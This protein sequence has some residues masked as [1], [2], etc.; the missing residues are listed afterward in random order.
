MTRLASKRLNSNFFSKILIKEPPRQQYNEAAR[1][2]RFL[3]SMKSHLSQGRTSTCHAI[4]LLRLSRHVK[5]CAAK[6]GVKSILNPFSERRA[7]VCKQIRLGGRETKNEI[8]L[9]I[10]SGLPLALSLEISRS[11]STTFYDSIPLRFLI[12]AL[13]W[14]PLV[15][16]ISKHTFSNFPVLIKFW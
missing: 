5:K 12:E 6:Q 3:F 7:K 1:I 4:L 8:R 11:Q 2:R 16:R 15:Y 13:N 9:I 14:R 10:S